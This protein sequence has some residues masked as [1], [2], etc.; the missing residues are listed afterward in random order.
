[1]DAAIAQGRAILDRA[2]DA[3]EPG[4]VDE[5][6]EGLV[7]GLKRLRQKC[8]HEAW[9]LF[10][11][12]ECI[13]HPVRFLVHQDP[14]TERAFFKPRGYPGDAVL[15][16]LFYG[17]DGALT[18]VERATA[19]GQQIYRYTSGAPAARALRRRKETLATIIDRVSDSTSD[20][21][22]MT[23]GCGHL[24]EA[25]LSAAVRHRRVDRFLA[26]DRDPDS[27]RVV[28]EKFGPF[29]VETAESTVK[30]LI[31]SADQLGQFDLVYAAGPYDHLN[32]LMATRLTEA[33]FRATR[34]G[35]LLLVTNFVHG[36]RD[37][38]YMEAFMDWRLNYRSAAD[39]FSLTSSIPE[40]EVSDRRTF[41]EESGGIVFLAV[42]RR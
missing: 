12:T 13:G 36:I 6:M 27:L 35:G 37:V 17:G 26:V 30:E 7:L 8:T 34:G 33:L 22:I 5:G 2:Y 41:S 9:E 24:R 42:R 14:L 16:D 15:L 23:L 39:M 1:M 40:D 10:C 29:G 31:A 32:R 38:G 4:R 18:Y 20:T 25:E 21:H 3:I 28:R 19:L 11:R